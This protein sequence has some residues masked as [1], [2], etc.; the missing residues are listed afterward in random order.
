M[1]A[2]LFHANRRTDR[3]RD[4]TK[5]TVVFR[6]FANAPKKERRLGSTGRKSIFTFSVFIEVYTYG[7]LL[8]PGLFLLHF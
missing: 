8:G 6:N 7:G 4:M 3:Q 5:L 1:G 2:E